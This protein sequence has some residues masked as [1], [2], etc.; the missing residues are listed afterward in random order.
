MSPKYAMS[1]P[2]Q[3]SQFACHF[4]SSQREVTIYGHYS[5]VLLPFLSTICQ[6]HGLIN[7]RQIIKM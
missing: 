2:T 3:S 6:M 5:K 7:R 1:S 4:W